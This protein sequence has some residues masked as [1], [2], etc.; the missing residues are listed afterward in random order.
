[1]EDVGVVVLRGQ[2]GRR[3]GAVVGGHDVGG[4]EEERRARVD[5][6]VPAVDHGGLVGV[7]VGGGGGVAY[8][9]GGQVDPPVALVGLDGLVFQGAGVG[10]VVDGA[11]VEGAVGVVL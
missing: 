8:A 11:E 1:M 2:L 9:H 3:H 5:D 10:G 4:R 6:G 7:V